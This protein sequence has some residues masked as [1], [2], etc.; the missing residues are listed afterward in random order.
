MSLWWLGYP[1][2]GAFAGFVAGLFG[3][4]G[5][6]TIVPLLCVPLFIIA[7]GMMQGT[8]TAL[9]P[10]LVSSGVVPPGQLDRLRSIL[11]DIARLRDSVLPWIAIFAA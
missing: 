3:V 5:G 6:L 1:L 7:E 11:G 2:L 4:G 9:L 10:R 8:L